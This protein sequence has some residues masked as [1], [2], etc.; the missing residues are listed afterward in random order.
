MLIDKNLSFLRNLS[1]HYVDRIVKNI[2]LYIRNKSFKEYFCI[3]KARLLHSGGS[4]CMAKAR[5]LHG[6]GSLLHSGGSVCLANLGGST[7]LQGWRLMASG[8]SIPHS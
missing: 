2:L 1:C 5:G 8:G 4:V 7:C 3:A 6:E